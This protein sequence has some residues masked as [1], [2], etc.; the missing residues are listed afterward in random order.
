M[1]VKKV[2]HELCSRCG[3]VD[4]VITQAG[5]KT[6]HSCQRPVPG[7]PSDPRLFL[8]SQAFFVSRYGRR[9]F[10]FE[11]AGLCPGD[12]VEV[13]DEGLA[14]L[15][16]LC[17]YMPPNHHGR[18]DKIVGD[19]IWVEFPI[20]GKYDG[21]SQLAPYPASMVKLRKA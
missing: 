5:I 3:K 21:H 17:P 8:W 12:P 9:H 18:I 15:R 10:V 14:R 7:P 11:D 20:D 4:A 19:E 16:A 2:C 13:S 6:G 1:A